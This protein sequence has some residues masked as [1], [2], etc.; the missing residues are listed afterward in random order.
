VSPAHRRFLLLENGLGSAF[1]NFL[2]NAGI[3]LLLFRHLDVVPL[4]GTESIAG[5]TIG[6][7]FFLPFL[8]GL[9]VTRLARRRV[10]AGEI[11]GSGWTRATHPVLGW[12]PRRTV[13]RSL[14]LGGLCAAAVAPAAIA[15]LTILDVRELPLGRFVLAKAVFAAVLAALVTPV[16]A[17]WAIAAESVAD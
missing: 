16:I 11:E 17:L 4:W 14:A 9:I 10:A 2:I 6:T 13:R 7:C 5:D 15:T 8:T 3:A 12:L 1:V